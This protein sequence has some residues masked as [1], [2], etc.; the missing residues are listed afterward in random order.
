MSA[1][2]ELM[3]LLREQRTQSAEMLGQMRKQGEQLRSLSEQL[4]AQGVQLQAQG[5]QLQAQGAQ[6][7]EVK[8]QML[9]LQGGRALQ[10]QGERAAPLPAAASIDAPRRAPAA[11]ARAAGGGGGGGG[12]GGP[13]AASTSSSKSGSSPPSP[14]AGGQAS[15]AGL[16]RL[17]HAFAAAPPPAPTLAIALGANS[18][19]LPAAVQAALLAHR[20]RT[21]ARVQD[22]DYVPVSF[23]ESTVLPDARKGLSVF[24]VA[25]L[26]AE[27]VRAAHELRGAASKGNLGC[28]SLP[29]ASLPASLVLTIDSVLERE[30]GG[31]GAPIVWHATVSPA[32]P[33]LFSA[34]EA[35]FC[36]W[37]GAGPCWFKAGGERPQ[38]ASDDEGEGLDLTC[39]SACSAAY[40][41]AKLAAHAAVHSAALGSAAAAALP[42]GGS[43]G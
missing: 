4:Q 8:E 1:E 3:Q 10:T 37:A 24:L 29:L 42:A 26:D 12:G 33:M 41:A 27:V 6:L 18:R 5:A 28:I 35:A 14:V 19:A 7:Q 13:S 30:G 36:G 16:A 31:A 38:E 2:T 25:S 21:P 39:L 40:G 15:P 32:A 23:T 9:E 34:F 20:L 43:P 17:R 11:G 22:F